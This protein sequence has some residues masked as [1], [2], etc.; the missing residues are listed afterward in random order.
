MDKYM[1][2]VSHV[3]DKA[4]IS[5]DDISEVV[6]VAK[7]HDMGPEFPCYASRIAHQIGSRPRATY[8]IRSDFETAM[9][10][11]AATVQVEDGLVLVIGETDQKYSDGVLVSED[12]V[13]A[14]LFRRER[15]VPFY[16]VKKSVPGIYMGEHVITNKDLEG[17]VDTSDKWIV[18]RTGI[19][20]RRLS[21]LSVSEM[22]YEAVMNLGDI[23]P[24]YD[25]IIVATNKHQ[26]D[27]CYARIL[28]DKI[29]IDT[30]AYDI[31]AGCTGLIYAKRIAANNIATGRTDKAL[32]VAVERL[33]SIGDYSDRST[34]ILWGDGAAA[35]KLER[36]ENEGIIACYVNGMPDCGNIEFPEGMLSLRK[37]SGKKIVQ[38]DHGFALENHDQ[39]YL[40][41]DGPEIFSLVV[42]SELVDGRKG[43][44]G[45]SI[46]GV[47]ERSPYTTKDI[48]IVVPHSANMRII[49]NCMNG[50]PFNGRILSNI[51]KVGNTSGA[52]IGLT[53]GESDIGPGKLVL[54]MGF[55]AGLTW[56]GVLY[57]S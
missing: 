54:N 35:Y 20:E 32:V 53:E 19:K 13:S 24:N 55:G 18:R 57:R 49:K 27:E 51:A 34:C 44:M 11:A 12:G 38:N 16:N 7:R 43:M 33:T 17:M 31:G 14:A 47:M 48:D 45:D 9:S 6:F 52:S 42:K 15:E 41:M 37:K 21:S 46:S 36:T 28:A 5:S 30:Q 26:N 23:D 25:E 2:T 39:D 10:I 50:Y 29:G 3:M 22:A 4:S 8:D 56:G 40:I 1:R